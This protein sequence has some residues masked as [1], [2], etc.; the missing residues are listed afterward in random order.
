VL[1]EGAHRS[2]ADWTLLEQAIAV[3]ESSLQSA[4]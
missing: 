2:G 3:T 4:A 1:S